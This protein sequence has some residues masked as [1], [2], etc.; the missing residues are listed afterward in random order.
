VSAPPAPLGSLSARLTRVALAALSVG[1]LVPCGAQADRTHH[2]P[3]H[4]HAII[5][6]I[7][8]DGPFKGVQYMNEDTGRTLFADSPGAARY[9]YKLVESATSAPASVPHVRLVEIIEADDDQ[10]S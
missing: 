8:D 1:T 7:C 6:V 3:V 9:V 2:G 5:R 10:F 4:A